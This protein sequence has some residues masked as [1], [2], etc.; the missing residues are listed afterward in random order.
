MATK[1]LSSWLE[2]ISP[3]I[4]FTLSLTQLFMCS[5]HIYQKLAEQN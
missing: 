1:D 2:S 5:W 4:V 3:T